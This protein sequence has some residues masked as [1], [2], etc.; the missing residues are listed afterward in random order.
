MVVMV[1]VVRAQQLMSNFL[2]SSPDISSR[3]TEKHFQNGGVA[4]KYLPDYND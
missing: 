3:G 2:H 4:A 1:A